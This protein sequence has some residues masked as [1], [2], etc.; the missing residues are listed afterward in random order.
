M[1]RM[2]KAQHT[3]RCTYGCCASGNDLVKAKWSGK[4]R[5]AAKQAIKR[6]MKKR[7]RQNALK[8]ES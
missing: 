3:G 8:G 1:A 5:T 2:I 4:H 6:S 7:D